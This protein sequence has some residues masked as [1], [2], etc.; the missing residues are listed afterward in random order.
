[1]ATVAETTYR[2]TQQNA[3]LRLLDNRR[4]LIF[5]FM[6]PAAGLLLIFLTYPLGLGV[7]LGFTDT[8][9]G[10]SGIF[11]GW[12]NYESLFRDRVF[13][14]AVQ[15]TRSACGSRCCLITSCRSRRSSARSSWCR[16]SC[17]RC[18]RQSRSGGST[19]RSSRSSAIR[20]SGSG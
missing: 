14:T 5:L 10:R 2:R 18:F 6:L 1:V 8:R 11:I 9:I 12:E 20:C 16:G 15:F 17:R 4:F 13:W 3:V 19:T 7:W